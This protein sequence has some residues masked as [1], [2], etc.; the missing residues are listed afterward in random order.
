MKIPNIFCKKNNKIF[1]PKK[2]LLVCFHLSTLFTHNFAPS[3]VVLTKESN[4]PH[5]HVA[6]QFL[7][8]CLHK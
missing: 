5:H 4:Y 7:L 3:E 6:H 1:P 2:S 8:G